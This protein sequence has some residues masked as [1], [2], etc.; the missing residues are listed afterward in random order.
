MLP[1]TRRD[2]VADRLRCSEIDDHLKIGWL[3]DWKIGHLSS[4]QYFY[5]HLRPIAVNLREARTIFC[6]ASYF[7]V[8][9]PLEDRRQPHLSG[10]IT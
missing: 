7:C 6:E 2:F 9:R 1:L 8:F 4:A 5:D 10:R 3:F